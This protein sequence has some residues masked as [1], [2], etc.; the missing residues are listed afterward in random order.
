MTVLEM[1]A[2]YLIAHHY[3]GLYSEG[4]CACKVSDL[5]PCG[6]LQSDCRAG[7]NT[8]CDGTCE[9]SECSWHM[10]AQKR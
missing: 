7:Y 8:P 4:R 5:A 1:V 10:G 6:E 9:S 3:D 2:A